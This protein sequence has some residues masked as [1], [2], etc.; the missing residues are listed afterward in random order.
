MSERDSY[1]ECFEAGCRKRRIMERHKALHDMEAA[2]FLPVMLDKGAKMPT[3]A[4]MCLSP[5]AMWA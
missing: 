3:R 4:C 2:M 1:E 5:K